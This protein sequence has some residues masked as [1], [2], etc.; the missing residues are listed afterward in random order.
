MKESAF[1]TLKFKTE[2]AIDFR[3]FSRELGKQQTETLQLMLNFFRNHCLSPSEDL[4]PNMKTLEA[5]LNKRISGV[6]SIIRNIEKTQTKPVLAMLQLLFQEDTEKKKNLLLEKSPAANEQIPGPD[7]QQK[8]MELKQQLLESRADLELL[9]EKI[10]V[11]RS[12]FGNPYLRLNL[13]VEEF[14]NLKLKYK[15]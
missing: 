4:G 7:F 9:L 10:L 13:K 14:Y 6:I 15:T 11:T 8:N 12:S 3:R 2:T 5:H 1:V